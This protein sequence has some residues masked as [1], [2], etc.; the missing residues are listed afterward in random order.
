MAQEKKDFWLAAASKHYL[1]KTVKHAVDESRVVKIRVHQKP[2]TSRMSWGETSGFPVKRTC[3][4]RLTIMRP[5]VD[6]DQSKMG[7]VEELRD[8][9]S[10]EHPPSSGKWVG[11]TV[12]LRR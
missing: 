9:W 3:E 12:I 4:E 10:E 11:A 7:P 8:N 1:A 2:R 5:L 6:K